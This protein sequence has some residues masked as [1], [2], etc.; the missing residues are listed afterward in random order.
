M[1]NVI[2]GSKKDPPDYF[3][4]YIKALGRAE[5]RYE[6]TESRCDLMS[7]VFYGVKTVNSSRE[8]MRLVG[9][10][11]EFQVTDAIKV[12]L[13]CL[14]PRELMSIFP[15]DKTYDGERRETKDYFSTMKALEDYD[16]DAEIGMERVDDF[17]WDYMNITLLVFNAHMSCAA[18]DLF[19]AETSRGLMESFLKEIKPDI[20]TYSIAADDKGREYMLDNKTGASFRIIKPIPNGMRVIPG[21][22]K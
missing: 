4:R 8:Y 20:T 18:D 13:S 10:M 7:F 6:A 17:L 5:D 12:M 2:K 21:G 11:R 9:P 15:V 19:K 16:L 3:D 14:T 1:F 22:L